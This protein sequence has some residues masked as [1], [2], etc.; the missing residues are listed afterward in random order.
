[1]YNAPRAATCR[2][3]NAVKLW[4]L[5]R[6]SFKCIVVAASLQKRE[7]YRTFL[8]TVTILNSLTEV[9][10]LTLSDSLAEE[11]YQDGQVI[12]NQGDDGLY[13][14]IIREV[15][16]VCTITDENYPDEN[17][18]VSLSTGQYFGEIALLTSK[19]RQATVKAKGLLKVIAIDRATFT[20]VFGALESILRRNMEEYKKFAA[21][22]I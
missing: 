20:R 2:A 6:V 15:E 5:D 14:Y 9:E 4:S 17:I 16:A 12:C 7:L 22:N 21:Q 19:A 3:K 13:F 18:T 10:V 11:I 8:Q 1:M